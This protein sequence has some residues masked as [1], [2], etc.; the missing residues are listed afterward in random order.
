MA[1]HSPSL[2]NF[3]SQDLLENSA[4]RQTFFQA[5]LKDCNNESDENVPLWNK[6]YLGLNETE[7]QQTLPRAGFTFPL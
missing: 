3:T 2:R 5:L 4:K 6:D 1:Q 7:K